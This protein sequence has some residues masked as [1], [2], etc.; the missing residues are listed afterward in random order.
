MAASPALGRDC[1]R[2]TLTSR[3]SYDLDAMRAKV[4]VQTGRVYVCNPNNPTA[5]LTGRRDSI[6]LGGLP[7]QTH[8]LIDEA[9]YQYADG[10]S[11][12]PTFL[13][14]PLEIS[15]SL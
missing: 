12:Y 2:G 4:D 9:Y 14:R 3:Y 8:V 1:C 10:A 6:F 15:G 13:E 11:E 5:T 7:A